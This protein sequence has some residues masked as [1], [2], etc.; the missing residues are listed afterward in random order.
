MKAKSVRGY[1]GTGSERSL[2][3]NIERRTSN[4]EVARPNAEGSLISNFQLR[5]SDLTHQ[6]NTGVRTCHG[7]SCAR[8]ISPAFNFSNRFFSRSVYPGNAW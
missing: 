3:S 5:N 8:R 4:G 7:F 6:R 2:I 1:E